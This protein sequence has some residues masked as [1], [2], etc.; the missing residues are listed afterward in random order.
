MPVKSGGTDN[1]VSTKDTV[2]MVL[3][4]FSAMLGF[5]LFFT[6]LQ[7]N[8]RPY[9]FCGCFALCVVCLL[10]ADKKKEIFWGGVAFILLRVAWG[11]V[12]VGA[13]RL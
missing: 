13:H 9:L 5:G 3:F 2:L 8:G 10:L 7:E 11:M 4:T 1:S 6:L 12:L